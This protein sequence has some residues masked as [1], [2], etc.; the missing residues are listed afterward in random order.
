MRQQQLKVQWFFWPGTH[1][2]PRTTWYD[3]M[4]HYHTLSTLFSTSYEVGHGKRKAVVDSYG[5][6]QQDWAEPLR[7][8]TL[9]YIGYIACKPIHLQDPARFSFQQEFLQ[10]A[11]SKTNMNMSVEGC[12]HWRTFANKPRVLWDFVTRWERVSSRQHISLGRSGF[13]LLADTSIVASC[14]CKE[15][16]CTDYFPT[17]CRPP[18]CIQSTWSLKGFE[19]LIHNEPQQVLQKSALTTIESVHFIPEVSRNSSPHFPSKRSGCGSHLA[20]RSCFQKHWPS[21]KPPQGGPIPSYDKV[22][23]ISSFDEVCIHSEKSPA[24]RSLPYPR[25]PQIAEQASPEISGSCQ[26]NKKLLRICSDR[27]ASK[28]LAGSCQDEL[29]LSACRFQCSSP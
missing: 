24:K 6:P 26:G 16:K 17:D 23:Q 29:V 15:K 11:G 18:K 20:F 8:A 19:Y 9:G 7:V 27:G 4:Q 22:Q 1:Q 3:D 25:S 12:L 2:E 28:K 21:A 10:M 13:T 5:M 14:Y